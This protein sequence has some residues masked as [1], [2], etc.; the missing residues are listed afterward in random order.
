[1]RNF[2]KFAALFLTVAMT[3]AMTACGGGNGSGNGGG[4]DGDKAAEAVTVTEPI[5]IEFWHTLSGEAATAIDEMIAD[6][7]STNEYGITVKG[8]YQGGYYDVL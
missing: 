6:F 4:K 5:E 8:T 2:K 7:N 1:M 3:F